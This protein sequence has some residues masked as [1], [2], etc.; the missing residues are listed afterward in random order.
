[1]RAW[2]E[3]VQQQY[4]FILFDS[5]PL[6]PVIDAVLV[7]ELSHGL[8]MVV[9]LDQTKKSDLAA[10]VQILDTVDLDI[11]GFALNKTSLPSSA[12]Y[13]YPYVK[14]PH[15]RAQRRRG[16]RRSRNRSRQPATTAP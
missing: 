8:L 3:T 12:A 6:V 5:P 13:G 1:M 9:A 16:R 11:S 7:G 14:A 15:T 4:D 2:M 10:A